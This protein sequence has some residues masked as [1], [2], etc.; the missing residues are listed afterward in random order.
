M[1]GYFIYTLE[2][3]ICLA[4]FY[5]AFLFLLR[6]DT[7]FAISRIYLLSSA[8][9]SILIP[10]INIP[11][12]Q[13][14]APA[15]TAVLINT[16]TVEAG[17][18]KEAVSSGISSWEIIAAIYLTGVLIFFCR[19]TIRLIQLMNLV[20]KNGTN[21]IDGY[22]IVFTEGKYSPFSFFNIIF[23]SDSF[24][25]SPETELILAHEKVHRDKHHTY[26]I[27]LFE[28]LLILQWFN[29]F[30]WLY[31]RSMQ[32]VHE[33]QAD[34]GV[35]RSGFSSIDYQKLILR[36]IGG[37]VL[38]QPATNFDYSLIKRRIKMLAKE[39]TRRIALMKLLFVLPISF[40]LFLSFS[41]SQKGSDNK[42]WNPLEDVIRIPEDKI[43]SH[44]EF[45]TGSK[46]MWAFINDRMKTPQELIAQ[47]KCGKLAVRFE[48]NI[49]GSLENIRV[50]QSKELGGE[51]K[52][53]KLGYGCDEEA[54][55]IISSMPKWKPAMSEGEPVK[56]TQSLILFFGT[57]EME[58]KWNET[59][60]NKDNWI[61]TKTD[62]DK[63]DFDIKYE[64]PGGY[65]KMVEFIKKNI[66]YPEEARKKGVEGTVVVVFNV[67][68]DGS[69]LNIKIDKSVGSGCDEE[70]IRIIKAMPKWVCKSEIAPGTQEVKLPIRF[71][72]NKNASFN[73]TKED[74]KIQNMSGNTADTLQMQGDEFTIVDKE[75][76]VDLADIAKAVKYPDA[77][78]TAGWEGLVNLKVL[79]SKSGYVTK[80]RIQRCDNPIFIESAINAVKS[81]KF[82]P[83]VKDYKNID[84]WVCVPI[85]F[86]LK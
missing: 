5:I 32:E 16:I 70:A 44:P 18:A 47:N 24:R 8:I 83:A 65:N 27:I 15:T 46:D 36:Q 62:L 54:I 45:P 77:A 86:R 64:F 25:H 11:G 58:A 55:K 41:C 57:K 40:V 67:Q 59:E 81:V 78:R 26:D 53:G 22:K 74:S 9:A 37:S 12:V 1:N 72:L 43:Q 61:E 39:K 69:L 42:L 7:F 31:K 21:K 29:P 49:D 50:A 76:M 35:V 17:K 19:F 66:Q 38:F 52:P 3:A 33:Y 14:G 2:S 80:V 68:K 85:M 75:P 34:E 79:V 51:W 20:R 73:E 82:I 28:I 84:C 48:V 56:L 4:V 30:V 60:R 63:K 10:L 13:S 6:R 23:L 71:K